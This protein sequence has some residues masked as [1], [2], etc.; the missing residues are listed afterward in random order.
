MV[1]ERMGSSRSSTHGAARRRAERTWPTRSRRSSR[2]VVRGEDVPFAKV[3]PFLDISEE[4]YAASFSKTFDPRKPIGNL[5]LIL[6]TAETSATWRA[7]LHRAAPAVLRRVL[8]GDGRLSHCSCRS[9]REEPSP[10]ELYSRSATRSKRTTRGTTRARRVHGGRRRRHDDLR[11]VGPRVQE[12]R[13][14]H[15]RRERFPREDGR[16]VAPAYGVFYAWATASSRGLRPAAPACTHGPTS[17]RRWAIRCRG[18]AGP[19]D[20]RVFEGGLPVA[21]VLTYR[22][23]ARRDAVA[24]LQVEAGERTAKSPEEEDQLRK[25]RITRLHQRNRSDPARPA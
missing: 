12:R 23:D 17:S 22:G 6:A 4:D 10:E 25:A 3:R 16:H 9:R 20:H 7:P 14:P 18:H 1:T 2:E 15:G 5:R 11:D 8:R 19:R 13:L 24:K 21:T